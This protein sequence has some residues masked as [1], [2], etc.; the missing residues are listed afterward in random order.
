MGGGIQ[1]ECV[2]CRAW[3]HAACNGQESFDV[4]QQ[5]TA[6]CKQ[7][8]VAIMDTDTGNY[9]SLLKEIESLAR[10]LPMSM[11][12]KFEPV[13]EGAKKK[14][15]V[16]TVR[17]L[18]ETETGKS[19]LMNTLVQGPPRPGVPIDSDSTKFDSSFIFE[20]QT[21]FD[22][23]G[24]YHGTSFRRE[25]TCLSETQQQE[26]K[27]ELL[28]YDRRNATEDVELEALLQARPAPLLMQLDTLEAVQQDRERM[29][30][31]HQNPGLLSK[32]T[33]AGE[34][35]VAGVELID[36]CG[37]NDGHMDNES[38]LVAQMQES[39]MVIITVGFGRFD[40][41]VLKSVQAVSDTPTLT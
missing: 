21:P 4:S 33:V 31:K 22:L 12:K 37:I 19:V 34:L 20:R 3:F 35:G 38:K 7:C 5:L 1:H 26:R 29:Y 2:K 36:C 24:D 14:E 11:W 18:G 6:M 40:G 9:R 39:D 30:Q 17:M 23:P 8:E 25:V 32:Y 16:F 27:T 41:D 15:E 13:F 28:S 10:Q